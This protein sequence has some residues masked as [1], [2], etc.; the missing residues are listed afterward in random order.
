M[1]DIT[2]ETTAETTQEHAADL[3]ATA[4][5]PVSLDTSATAGPGGDAPRPGVPAAPGREQPGLVEHSH[6]AGADV[7]GESRAARPT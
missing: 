6:G 7:P 3:G 5:A 4:P 1:T 2:A